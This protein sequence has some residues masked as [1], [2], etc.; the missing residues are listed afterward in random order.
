ME[1]GWPCETHHGVKF[2]HLSV[3]W[4]LLPHSH[5]LLVTLAKGLFG[6][7]VDVSILEK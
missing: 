2:L 4:Q 6:E 5:Y 7:G 1:Q 3:Y